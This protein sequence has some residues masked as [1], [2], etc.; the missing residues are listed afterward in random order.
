MRID[1]EQVDRVITAA[2]TGGPVPRATILA[3]AL[4]WDTLEPVRERDSSDEQEPASCA[5]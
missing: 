4:L 2:L 1:S 3:L 5:A